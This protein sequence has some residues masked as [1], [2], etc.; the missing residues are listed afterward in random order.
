MAK[1]D[2]D[3]N[4]LWAKLA[5]SRAFDVDAS[6]DGSAYFT[7]FHSGTANTLGT[8]TLSVVSGLDL[9]IAKFDTAGHTA[10][11]TNSG[12]SANDIGRAIVQTP[13]GSTFGIGEAGAEIFAN[14]SFS[15]TVYIVELRPTVTLPPALGLSLTS[16][17][18]VVSWPV[19]ETGYLIETVGA[20]G[21]TFQQGQL[22]FTPVAGQTNVFAT[23]RPT[24]NIFIR[25]VKP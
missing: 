4:A 6:A 24:T 21:A 13:G 12:T 1:F 20:L 25:L 10:W 7:G 5:G 9:W 22:P 19:G 15:P 3:G 2:A 23:P 11:A 8:N 17:N 18:L 16:S 14:A